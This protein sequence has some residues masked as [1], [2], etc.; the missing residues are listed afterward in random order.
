ML[1]S[2]TYFSLWDT[3]LLAKYLMIKRPKK[4]ELA[5]RANKIQLRQLAR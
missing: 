1:H 5:L 2:I 4:V 3:S